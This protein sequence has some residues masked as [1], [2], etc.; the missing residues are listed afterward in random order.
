MAKKIRIKIMLHSYAIPI[1]LSF[2]HAC[3]RMEVQGKQNVPARGPDKKGIII[4]S[5]HL[6]LLDPF[7]I[8]L[9]VFPRF[10]KPF[11]YPADAK[12][13][14]LP[15]FRPILH[16]MNCI[17]VFKGSKRLDIV[18]Y[19]IAVV[20]G[21]GSVVYFPEG[22][23]TKDGKLQPGKLG[24]GLLAHETKT[25]VIPCA[26]KNTAIAMPVGRSFTLGGG[27]RRLVL[28]VK[29]GPPL[30]LNRFYKLPSR[31]ETSQA[32]SDFIMEEIAK[33]LETM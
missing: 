29:F 12:L 3:Y 18:K 13:W 5:N 10:Y 6:S 14:K 2:F 26:V 32:I 4:M 11:F 25:M 9:S 31:K 16:G 23:R 28:K 24:A 8:G 19:N 1:L 33:L 7:F 21:G 27:P 17:P 20:R 22:A 30:D 15:F